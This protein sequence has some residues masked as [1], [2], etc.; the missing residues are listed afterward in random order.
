MRDAGLGPPPV[1]MKRARPAVEIGSLRQYLNIDR[2]AATQIGMIKALKRQA[3]ALDS[4]LPGIEKALQDREARARDLGLYYCRGRDGNAGSFRAYLDDLC[5]G[6]DFPSVGDVWTGWGR[7]LSEQAGPGDYIAKIRL[8]HA[9]ERR[10]DP[11]MAA[12]VPNIRHTLLTR[13]YPMFC[14]TR[15]GTKMTSVAEPG[16]TA[17]NERLVGVQRTVAVKL[18]LRSVVEQVLEL[19]VSSCPFARQTIYPCPV[20]QPSSPWQKSRCVRPTLNPADL[21][22]SSVE[23]CR[24]SPSSRLVRRAQRPSRRNARLLPRTARCARN[25]SPGDGSVDACYFGQLFSETFGVLPSAVQHSKSTPLVVAASSAP[26]WGR[27]WLCPSCGAAHQADE[28]MESARKTIRVM[29]EASPEGASV[30]AVGTVD[31]GVCGVGSA[32]DDIIKN[33]PD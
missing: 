30:Q 18:F 2:P 16:V 9:M 13:S 23:Y 28:A 33:L 27:S 26:V 19:G 8:E 21:R 15:A 14:T 11:A 29:A 20:E 22:C 3:P 7:L 31:C 32:I 4:L 17:E 25:L 6:L 5:R 1:P 12:S 10:A 24:Y